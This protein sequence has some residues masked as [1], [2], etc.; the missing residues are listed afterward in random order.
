VP[1]EIE[2]QVLDAA[3]RVMDRDGLAGLSISAIAEEAGLSRVTLHRRGA[4]LDD[5][6]VAVLGRASDDLRAS[7]WPVL[8]GPDTAATRLRDALEILCEVC[9]RHTG[10]MTAMYAKP[11]RPLP[12]KPGRTTSM[13]FIEPFERLLR[14]GLLDGSLVCEDPALEA[15]L[16]A[17][18]VA[19]T[20][21]HMRQAHRW[22][23]TAATARVIGLATA[24]LLPAQ[25]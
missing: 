16:V 12:D 11:A 6:L 14:D 13:E 1:V 21:L 15:T 17:N 24:H 22:E 9:E 10:V 18:A 4:R 3:A 8:T 25:P 5:Y 2:E 20:Y 19:W 7:L 23:A